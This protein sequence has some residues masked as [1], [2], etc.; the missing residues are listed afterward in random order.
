L[1][2]PF[3]HAPHPDAHPG[4]GLTFRVENFGWDSATLVFD[5]ND[6]RVFRVLEPYPCE[7]AFRVTMDIRQCFLNDAE[8]STL[9][10]G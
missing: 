3:G 6:D 2:E 4:Q 10:I 8:K 9:S 7:R 1:P 5:G